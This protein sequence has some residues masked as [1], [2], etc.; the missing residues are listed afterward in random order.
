[1]AFAFAYHE[2]SKPEYL[3]VITKYH[4]YLWKEKD[5]FIV[6][7]D[8]YALIGATLAASLTNDSTAKK[9]SDYFAEKLLSKMNMQTGSIPAEYYEAPVGSHLVDMIYTVN[10]ALL[11]MQIKASMENSAKYR[12]AFESLLKLVIDIQDNNREKQFAGCWRG[13]F[14][15]ESNAWGGR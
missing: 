14:D 2:N 1:M 9:V 8:A 5:S 3:K 15:L 10:W 7:E 6:S 13:M 11:G 4:Q 12:D